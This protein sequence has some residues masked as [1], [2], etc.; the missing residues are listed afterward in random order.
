MDPAHTVTGQST[1][2][3]VDDYD[4]TGHLSARSA[5]SPVQTGTRALPIFHDRERTSVSHTDYSC[6]AEQLV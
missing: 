1:D 6:T 4:D 3:K 5:R 2:L